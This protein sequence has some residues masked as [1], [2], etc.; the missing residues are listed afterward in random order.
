MANNLALVGDFFKAKGKGN[1]SSRLGPRYSISLLKR[2][3]GLNKT[4]NE[5]AISKVGM[6][7]ERMR[8]SP[9]EIHTIQDRIR[10]NEQIRVI[11]KDVLAHLFS[12]LGETDYKITPEYL[13][14]ANLSPHLDE[15]IKQKAGLESMPPGELR[16]LDA[17]IIRLKFAATFVSYIR[18]IKSLW[19]TNKAEAAY[20]R[21][22]QSQPGATIGNSGPL[23]PGE[24]LESVA[25]ASG[26]S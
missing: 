6:L 8:V 17:L 4:P 19:E 13:N 21:E 10:N 5:I 26:H 12:F 24:A 1:R 16:D 15:Q 3:G 18:N 14:F 9:K 7:L 2:T 22:I 20:L 25:S 23:Y 11:N